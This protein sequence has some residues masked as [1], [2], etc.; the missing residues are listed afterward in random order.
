MATSEMLRAE[1]SHTSSLVFLFFFFF[2]QRTTKIQA[3]FCILDTGLGIYESKRLRDPVCT[4]QQHVAAG[5]GTANQIS[6]PTL[7]LEQH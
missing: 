2:A 1:N 4:G 5:L 7:L 3:T 6:E